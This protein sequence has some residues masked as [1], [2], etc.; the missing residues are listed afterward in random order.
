LCTTCYVNSSKAL[1]PYHDTEGEIGYKLESHKINFST[2]LFRLERPFANNVPGIVNTAV[3]GSLSGTASCLA[4]EIIG[5]QINYGAEGML[6]GRVFESLMITGGITALDPKLTSTGIAATNKKDFVGIPAYKSNILAEYHLPLL[7]GAFFNF[8][9]QFVGR[10]PVDDIN[11]TYV[12]RYDDFD[13]GG[14]YTAKVFGKVATW[15][16]T[17]NNVSDVHYWSTLGPGSI[18]GQSSGSYLGHLGEPRLVTAS[19]RYDF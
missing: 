5:N 19:M 2:A 8:D 4:W 12:P 13:L 10:R 16:V 14:R 11:S 1:A 6:S 18:T 15:R 7:T 3:C 9:W 17:L